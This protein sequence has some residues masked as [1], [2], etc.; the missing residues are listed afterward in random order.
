VDAYVGRRPRA[1]SLN[2]MKR[3]DLGCEDALA[4]AFSPA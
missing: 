2:G 3:A 4:S 1:K